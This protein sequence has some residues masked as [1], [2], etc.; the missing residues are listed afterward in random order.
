VFTYETGA[1]LVARSIGTVSFDTSALGAGWTVGTLALTD[2]GNGTIYLTGLSKAGGSNTFANWI[3]TF[4]GV[5]GLT[6]VGD[7]ADGDGIDN[8]VENFFG[9]NPSIS[10]SGLVAGAVGVN[11]FTFTHPQN[12]TPASDL[13]AAYQWSKDLA[14]FNAGGVTDGDN[15]KVDFTTQL[16]TPVAGTTTVTATVTGTATSKLFVNIKV[17]QN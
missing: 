10:N 5:G 16:D 7:D 1:Q 6:G 9:T 12:A 14:T 11:T 8:G 13:T 17:T 2:D 15:T 3:A 4:P